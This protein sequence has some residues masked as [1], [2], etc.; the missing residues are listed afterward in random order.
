MTSSPS[1]S[2][3]T[4]LIEIYKYDDEFDLKAMIAHSIERRLA[5]SKRCESKSTTAED[6]A[7]ES[8]IAA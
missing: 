4:S 2:V 5:Y 6:M 3:A 7:I 1:P 8:F